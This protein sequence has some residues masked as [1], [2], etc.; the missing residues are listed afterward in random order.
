MKTT[1]IIGGITITLINGII[2]QPEKPIVATVRMDRLGY[3]RL[4]NYHINNN[5]CLEF[6]DGINQEIKF[7]GSYE[8]HPIK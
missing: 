3:Y 2:G 5:K 6:V 1:L 4:T 7:C 8:L